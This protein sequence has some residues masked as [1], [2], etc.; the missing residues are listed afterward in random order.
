MSEKFSWLLRGL[1]GGMEPFELGRGKEGFMEEVIF[2]GWV[3][4]NT[5]VGKRTVQAQYGQKPGG[6]NSVLVSLAL[7]GGMSQPDRPS[8]CWRP[9]AASHLWLPPG[10][11]SP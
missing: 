10:R 7:L 3:G 9:K 11:R 5:W 6:T 4:W 2:E 1:R 8:Q